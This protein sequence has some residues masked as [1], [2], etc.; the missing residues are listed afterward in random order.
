MNLQ[1]CDTFLVTRSNFGKPCPCKDCTARAVGCHGSCENYISWK[2][3]TAKLYE[4][5]R[6]VKATN[7]KW[8]YG[9]AHHYDEYSGY[10]MKRLGHRNYVKPAGAR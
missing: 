6:P 1:K 8:E 9:G 4:D 5:N 10:H 7:T 2:S 3:E